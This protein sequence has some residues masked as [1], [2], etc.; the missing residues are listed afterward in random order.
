MRK[1]PR[2]NE[3]PVDNLLLDGCERAAP[4]FK[5]AGF[6]PNDITSLSL[7]SGF[8]ST[9]AL[10]NNNILAFGSL[11]M[12]SYYFDCQDGYNA[13]QYNMVTEFGDLY[14]HVKDIV[15]NLYILSTIYFMY[16]PNA[17]AFSALVAIVFALMYM[18]LGCSQKVLPRN[19]D[20]LEM[21]RDFCPSGYE[22]PLKLFSPGTFQCVVV[23]I[24]VYLNSKRL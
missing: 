20:V 7:I 12:L 3:G 5:R 18:H 4:Y 10:K 8:M 21:T 13:R 23:A 6:V 19:S 15:L 2:E 22:A 24:V 16:K 9:I 17:V 11:Y 1:V 14:D